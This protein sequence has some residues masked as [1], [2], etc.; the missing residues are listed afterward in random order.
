MLE[1]IQIQNPRVGD[2]IENDLVYNVSEDKYY[3]I[4]MTNT[5]NNNEVDIKF[6]SIKSGKERFNL[7]LGI[8][9]NELIG[10]VLIRRVDR[11]RLVEMVSNT[12]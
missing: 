8:F 4:K 3:K 12:I 9:Y 6:Y 1:F 10:F 11:E 5:L 2:L 7:I